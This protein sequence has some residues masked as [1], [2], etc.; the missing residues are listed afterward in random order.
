ME[1]TS[2]A[3]HE[4]RKNHRMSHP[5]NLTGNAVNKEFTKPKDRRTLPQQTKVPSDQ[6][7]R[8][9]GGGI[10]GVLQHRRSHA[11]GSPESRTA[12]EA[13]GNCGPT[14]AHGPDHSMR[15]YSEV[16]CRFPYAPSAFLLYS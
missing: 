12:R 6:K 16:L 1:I 8:L 2:P 9:F 11:L 7:K 13:G 5:L 10:T 14:P 4:R 15:S 3:K